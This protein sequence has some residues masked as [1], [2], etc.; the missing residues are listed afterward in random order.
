LAA[1]EIES[2][3]VFLA[4][5]MRR[6]KVC[7]KE[8]PAFSASAQTKTTWGKAIRSVEALVF[9]ARERLHVLRREQETVFNRPRML[10]SPVNL[11]DKGGRRSLP[12]PP[13]SPGL[14][15]EPQVG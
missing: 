1:S 4:D 14:E 12:P 5:A 9:V 10:L 8:M 3:M 13:A 7:Y 11:K 6:R 15:K 2:A